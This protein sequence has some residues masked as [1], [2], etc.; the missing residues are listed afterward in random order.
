MLENN[1]KEIGLN[2]KEIRV[3]LTLLKSGTNK[4]GFIAKLIDMPKTSI[5]DILNKLI[6]KSLVTKFKKKNAYFFTAYEPGKILDILNKQEEDI[7]NLKEKIKKI[8]PWLNSLQNIASQKPQ[9]EY[10]EGKKGLIDAFEDTLRIP[11]KNIFVYGS[12]NAQA[13]NLPEIF[14]EYF[15]RRI[16]KKISTT[17]LIP[18]TL[19]SLSECLLNDQ[20]HLRKTY[21][22]P[23]E[24]ELPIEIN[25]Y[26]NNTA[27]MSFEE[28]F[29]VII[30]SKLIADCLK[31][32]FQLAFDGAQKYD[33]K[34]RSEVNLEQMK[35]YYKQWV[36]IRKNGKIPKEF[37][38]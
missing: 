21:Y 8:L 34:I 28:K 20:R 36:K 3:Y 37:L 5:L 16:K 32:I 13:S 18:A 6:Q 33:K 2:N 38:Q 4:A 24:M 19:P 11:K 15:D 35:K 27:I 23:K 22:L 12:V 31:I 9:I 26:E 1:L 29:A 14:P 7:K 10:L 30:R 25:I 17:C